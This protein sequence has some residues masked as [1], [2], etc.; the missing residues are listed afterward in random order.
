MKTQKAWG[1]YKT[2][3][4]DAPFVP[5][6]QARLQRSCGICCDGHLRPQTN[7][8]TDYIKY[9]AEAYVLRAQAN[10]HAGVGAFLYETP[11]GD[12]VRAYG[13]SAQAGAGISRRLQAV[14][15]G[16]HTPGYGARSSRRSLCQSR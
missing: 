10:V 16:L 14:M 5:R 3:K 8:E 12:I 1:E 4:G 11:E 9:N 15:P 2:I 7:H 6:K 13:L